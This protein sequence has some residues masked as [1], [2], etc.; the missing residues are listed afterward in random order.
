[1]NMK[2]LLTLVAFFATLQASAQQVNPVPDYVFRNQMSV[3]RGTVTDTAA[4]FSIGPRYGANK[5]FM[6]PIV[7]DTATFSSGKR[8]GLLIFSVQKNKFLYW[9]S[10]RVQW[11]DM[12]GSS[13]AYIVAGDTAAML[14][15]YVRHAGYGLTKSGQSFLVDTLNIST[16]AWR[17]KGLDSLAALEISGS[18][19]INRSAKFTASGS[20]GN[21]SIADSSSSIA[22]T[23]L[24]N[25]RIGVNTSI[26]AGYQLDISGNFRTTS[27]SNFATTSGN[28]GIATTS[29][30]DSDGFGKALDIYGV[31]G[32]AI[33]LRYATAP[34]TQYGTIGYDRTGGGLILS[35]KNSIPIIFYQ[36][37][38]ETMRFNTSRE[39]QLGSSSDMGSFIFQATGSGIFTSSLVVSARPSAGSPAI[40]TGLN[41][42]GGDSV[43][44]A[45]TPGVLTFAAHSNTIQSGEFI[46]RIQ[47][48][49]NDNSTSLSGIVGKIDLLAT[50]AF[51]AG[52]AQTA[53]T[54]HTNT[55]VAGSITEK[56]RIHHNGGLKFV[57]QSAAPVA[58]AG[59][60]YY[61]TDDNKLKVY[62]GTTW[63]DLH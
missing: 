57:G 7:G 47:F 43:T 14:S 49:S 12:A 27:T 45:T 20:I 62:N 38:I 24:S 9:D 18:G 56:I 26:D 19:T 29:P 54:F 1:M 5:G 13:G 8:N 53:M 21:G 46:G 34:T 23:I 61:D 33:Y 25:Q 36:N 44:A 31:N 30:T 50:S 63:V 28:V 51:T 6:P 48:L 60:V 59:T 32:A 17:Q 40:Q 42:I 2:R 37:S 22:M 3:G 10:V 58:E 39:M 15:P 41:I 4:Y 55:G 52:E 16:R 35:T 11:S